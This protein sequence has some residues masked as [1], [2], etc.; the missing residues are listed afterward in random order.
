MPLAN[1][2][3]MFVDNLL[4][5]Q[6]N[7]NEFLTQLLPLPS[8]SEE[9]QLSIYKSN[10][11]GAYQKVLGQIYPACLNILGEGYFNQL[12]RAYRFKHP[13]TDSDL[14][15]YGKFFSGFIKEQYNL[16]DELNDFEYLTDLALLEWLW[17][18]SF[19]ADNDTS[20]AFD[21]L[22]KVNLSEQDKLIFI[23]SY[24]F[25]LHSS[26]YPV[27]DIWK[28]NT[29]NVKEKQEFSMPESETYFC[30]SRVKLFP[31]I[32][33]LSK[34]QYGVL[35]SISN[36][37]SLTQ[38][39]GLDFTAADDFQSELMRF[40]QNGWVTGFSLLERRD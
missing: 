24:S 25:S 36:G 38:L 7:E 8:L 22:A 14:N 15:N 12:C 10:I 9:K 3:K 21:K 28:A 19:Y 33:L 6:A 5:S 35:K 13:S 31:E 1:I 39:T 11:N 17:H 18:A 30:I 2:E 37:L 34:Y 23:L 26:I 40:I 4:K 29:S 32:T 27:L 20:F 16:H